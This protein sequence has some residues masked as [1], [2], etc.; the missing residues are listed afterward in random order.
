MKGVMP[1]YQSHPGKQDFPL[2]LFAAAFVI[3][4]LITAFTGGLL[5]QEHNRIEEMSRKHI[6]LT[7]G[8]RGL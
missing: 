4:L 8:E 5:W 7:E 2:R 1:L 3:S 6:A